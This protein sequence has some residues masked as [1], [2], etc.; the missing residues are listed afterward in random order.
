MDKIFQKTYCFKWIKYFRKIICL[1][2][3]NILES[4]LIKMDKKVLK[5]YCFKC[6]KYYKN[7]IG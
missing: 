7:L 6:I 3:L 2:G 1:N 4:S 5:T